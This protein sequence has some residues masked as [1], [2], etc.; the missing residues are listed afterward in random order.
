[1]AI[2]VYINDKNERKSLIIEM[3]NSNYAISLEQDDTQDE[4]NRLT[5]NIN[6]GSCLNPRQLSNQVNNLKIHLGNLS[7][8]KLHLVNHKCVQKH[9]IL[10]RQTT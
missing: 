2:G 7:N 8:L 4:V 5:D 10:I 9:N 3:L 6:S 1:M